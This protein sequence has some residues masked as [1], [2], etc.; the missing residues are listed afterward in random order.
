M[1]QKRK[2]ALEHEIRIYFNQFETKWCSFIDGERVL[3]Q[4]T[5]LMLT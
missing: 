3:N 1:I 5:E 4:I 2:H